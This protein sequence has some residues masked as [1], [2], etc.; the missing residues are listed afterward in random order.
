[1]A[2]IFLKAQLVPLIEMT[3]VQSGPFFNIDRQ[4]DRQTD[5]PPAL[6]A[7]LPQQQLLPVSERNAFRAVDYV[8]L[9]DWATSAL[10]FGIS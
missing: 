4:T 6:A 10:L 7:P 2:E 9:I 1:M 3:C 5:P 8:R